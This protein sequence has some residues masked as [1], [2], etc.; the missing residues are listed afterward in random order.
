MTRTRPLSILAVTLVA[1]AIALP[2]FGSESWA[3][4]QRSGNFLDNLFG[5]GDQQGQQ[6]QQRPAAA[7]QQSGRVAQADPGDL[8]VRFDRMENALRQLTGTIEQL[9]YR[10]QQL[11][12]QLK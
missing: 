7:P 12:M 8:S 6:Q 9:Q 4:D 2:I 10:N 3:Q 1:S 5:R 11:E